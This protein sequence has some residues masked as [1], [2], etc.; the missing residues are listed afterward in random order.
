M[1]N[2]SRYSISLILL[3]A[4]P[5]GLFSQKTTLEKFNKLDVSNGIDVQLIMARENAI[6]IDIKNLEPDKVTHEIS[7]MTLKVRA[8]KGRN[9]EAEVLVKL[10]YTSLNSI[11]TSGRASVWSEEELYVETIHLNIGNGGETRLR[12]NSDSLFASVAEG[13][14]LFLKGQT[15][16][17]NVKAGTGATFSGYDFQSEQAIVLAS[18]GGKAKIAVSKSL[19]ATANSKGF[20]GYIGDPEKLNQSTSLGGEIVKTYHE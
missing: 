12:I 4:L 14:I 2:I 11:T 19:D 13:A 10:Y 18:S 3:L 8:T 9:K 1:K 16:Y 6:E 7:D 15:S 5:A 20:I 17:L